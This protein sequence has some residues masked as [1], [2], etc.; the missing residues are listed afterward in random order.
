MVAATI[1]SSLIAISSHGENPSTQ[2]AITQPE[3]ILFAQLPESIDQKVDSAD[4]IT[5]GGDDQ[6]KSDPAYPKMV[7]LLPPRQYA[8]WFRQKS[9]SHALNLCLFTMLPDKDK[10]IL[11]SKG[12]AGFQFSVQNVLLGKLVDQGLEMNV[13]VKESKGIDAAN[14]CSLAGTLEIDVRP[15]HRYIFPFDAKIKVEAA[16]GWVY[17]KSAKIIWQ[18]PEAWKKDD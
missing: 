4:L 5:I 16:N 11:P 2:P 18:K 10:V 17:A 7:P 13:R 3:K 6:P 1:A 8:D 9:D 14:V 15:D 12:P